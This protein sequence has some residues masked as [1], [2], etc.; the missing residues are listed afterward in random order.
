M[1]K[2]IK[3]MIV[4]VIIPAIIC[5]V[6]TVITAVILVGIGAWIVEALK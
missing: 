2:D 5:T 6:F 3:E 1:I 4:Q